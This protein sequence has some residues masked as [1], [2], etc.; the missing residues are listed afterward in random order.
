MYDELDKRILDAVSRREH[1]LYD[2]RTSEEAMRIARETGRE[3]FRVID[4]R[5]QA[6][7]KATRIRHVTKAGSNGQGGWHIVPDS[8]RQTR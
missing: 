8:D 6:L 1:P 2:R 5:I 7:R 4:G 3:G